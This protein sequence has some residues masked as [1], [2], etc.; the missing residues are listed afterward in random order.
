MPLDVA[1]APKTLTAMLHYLKR[2]AESR[3][4]TGSSR[5]RASQ[6]ERH[7]RPARGHDRGRARSGNGVHARPQRLS[8]GHGA[9]GGRRLLFARR[10]SSASTI[11]EG[12]RGCCRTEAGASRVLVFDHNVRNATRP[13]PGGALAAG[14]QR[15]HGQLGAASRARPD[16]RRRRGAAA[17]P[18]RHRQCV[19]AD[20]RASARC[21]AGAV[22]RARVFTDDDLIASDLVYAHV[23]GKT[24]RR[25]AYNPAHRW[26]SSLGDASPTR[27][28]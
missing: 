15:P 17:A 6:M 25:V 24:V 23:R 9:D 12:R 20:P 3:P 2:G 26:Y 7:R 28:C 8:A 16:G 19:A 10:R 5:R 14:P 22:R 27:C 1:A 21:A 13:G 18:L 11:R 4:I